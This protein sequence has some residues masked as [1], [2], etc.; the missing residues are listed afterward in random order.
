[1]MLALFI[2]P[3]LC[4]CWLDMVAPVRASG[5]APKPPSPTSWT[6]DTMSHHSDIHVMPNEDY[7]PHTPERDCWCHP[8][9]DDLAGYGECVV[10]NSLDRREDYQDGRLHP[11]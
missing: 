1:M 8:H 7:R 5:S 6:I 10:H 4:L 9:I 11:H 3:V 2:V